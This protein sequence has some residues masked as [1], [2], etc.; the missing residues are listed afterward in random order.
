MTPL[1]LIEHYIRWFY[2]VEC[3]SCNQSLVAWCILCGF[4]LNQQ[5]NFG[6]SKEVHYSNVDGGIYL[7]Q[8]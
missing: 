7:I 6:S 4:D 8:C 1:C 3:G 2:K 5:N